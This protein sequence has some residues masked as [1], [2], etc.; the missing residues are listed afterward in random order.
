[1]KKF[2]IVSGIVL[3]VL[4]LWLALKDV[5]FT[6]V[7]TAFANANLFLIIPLLLCNAVFYWLRAIRWSDILSPRYDI[8]AAKLTPSL[9]AGAAGNNLLPV[10]AGEVVRIYLAGSQFNISNATVLASLV[11]E[12]LMDMLA[13]L[14]IFSAA[15]LIGDYPAAMTAAG[16]ALLLF[17]FVVATIC[18]LIVLYT[19]ASVQF[20]RHRLKWPAE[21][22]RHKIADQMI[23]LADGLSLLKEKKLLIKVIINSLVQWLLLAACVY[24]SFLAFDINADFWLAV[25]VVGLIVVGLTLP[26]V[27]GFFGTIEYCFVLGL[28]AAGIDPSLAISAGI[29]YHIPQWFGV[30]VV[31]LVIAHLNSFSFNK[32]STELQN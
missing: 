1:M 9:M 6:D 18:T 3:S 30:T 28:T 4:F 10:H 23:N 2:L 21:K 24:F 16:S 5:N 17:V 29:F 25:V 8:S 13:V 19:D 22:L 20:I 14:L 11:V 31:G 12:R 15:T 26:T 27:P 7:S 32:I